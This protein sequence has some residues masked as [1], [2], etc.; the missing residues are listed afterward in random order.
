MIRAALALTLPLFT[1]GAA[2]TALGGRRLEPPARRARWVKFLVFLLIVHGV[3]ALA[4]GGRPAFA[5]LGLTVV[6]AG[7]WELDR[8]LLRMGP[9]ARRFRLPA[10]L[11]F[12]AFFLGC[13]RRPAQITLT[14]FLA[15]AAFDGLSQVVG[16]ALGR[17]PLAPAISPAK[18][19]E[20][21]AGGMAGAVLAALVLGRAAG[22]GAGA[23]ALRGL[24]LGLAALAGD[25]AGSWI[26]RRAGI[27]DFSTLLPGQ[28][29]I[30]DRFGSFM[31][32]VILAG[33]FL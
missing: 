8:A 17:R 2:L 21:F 20:G 10:G 27:K 4:L 22:Q 26:K 18:T 11:V 12:A 13:W 9:A 1:L 28:G 16:Q 6:L 3:L 5:A 14:C 19:W 7:G 32:A 25:L 33:A 29:G 23:A 24:P 15:A 30:L 31:G